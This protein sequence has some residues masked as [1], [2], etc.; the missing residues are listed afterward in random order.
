MA[1]EGYNMHPDCI[2]AIPDSFNVRPMDLRNPRCPVHGAPIVDLDKA[3]HEE[4]ESAIRESFRE[5][6]MGGRIYM[7]MDSSEAYSCASNLLSRYDIR[8]K[9]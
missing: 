7:M 4:I 2:C 6:N 9:R 3:S 1:T 8:R 5:V